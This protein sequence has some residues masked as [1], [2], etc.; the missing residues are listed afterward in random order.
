MDPRA[1]TRLR[2]LYSLRHCWTPS[3]SR[4]ARSYECRQFPRLSGYPED[5]AT[6]ITA[7]ALAATLQ[8]GPDDDKS[9]TIVN[10]DIYQGTAMRRPSLLQVVNLRRDEQGEGLISFGLQGQ[11]NTNATSLIRVSKHLEE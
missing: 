11:V 7:A 5:P 10:Y 6:V 8:I 3:G 9:S 2:C 1:G 4:G